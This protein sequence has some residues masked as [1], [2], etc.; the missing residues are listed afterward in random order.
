M[1]QHFVGKRKLHAERVLQIR[2]PSYIIGIL[3]N[4]LE[5]EEIQIEGQLDTYRDFRYLIEFLDP[6]A[7]PNSASYK[8][9]YRNE[10]ANISMQDAHAACKGVDKGK[11]TDYDDWIYPHECVETQGIHIRD[12]PKYTDHAGG[13]K[14][15]ERNW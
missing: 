10:G 4:F 2:E 1:V 9:E 13:V 11:I 6:K 3:L 5:T 15:H 7:D 12:L 8:R 14:R